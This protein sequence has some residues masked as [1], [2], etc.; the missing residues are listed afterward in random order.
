MK[1]TSPLKP[2][3]IGNTDP[4]TPTPARPVRSRARALVVDAH[5]EP[6]QHP[7]AQLAYCARGLIQ[8]TVT[9]RA[10]HT[11]FIL[12][13]SRAV[14]I[15]PGARHA[16][17]VLEATE[18][19][20]VYL[21]PSATPADW[22]DC[23]VLVVSSLLRELIQALQGSPEGPRDDALMALTLHEII[24]ADTQTLGVPLPRDKRLRSLCEAVL[25]SP[26]KRGTLSEWAAHIG[27]SERTVARLFRTELATSYPQWRQ[28]AVLAHALPMLARGAPVSQVASASG[29]TSDS[30]FSAMFKSAMGQSPSHFQNKNGL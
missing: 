3:V 14:W 11:T 2:Q 18:L 1:H 5:F 12:P 13:P 25:R 29:Y 30:A 22:L 10:T 16:V 15:P 19:R 20:T 6:H 21:D 23:R 17:T 27:A 7:W 26:G 4:V 8:V 24:H 28:Q 9:E